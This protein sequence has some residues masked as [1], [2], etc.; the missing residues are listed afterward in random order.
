MAVTELQ[1][2]KLGQIMDLLVREKSKVHYAQ[3]RPMR[4]H[5]ITSLHLLQQELASPTGITMDCSESITL[6]C[7]LAG[8]ND[9]NGFKYDGTG[10]TGTLL[11]H[12]PHYTNPQEARTGALVVFGP[13][14]GDH[15]CMVRNPGKDPLLFSHGSENGPIWI[16][17]SD[18]KKYQHAPTTFLRISGLSGKE[19][20]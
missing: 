14:S 17:L 11:H 18:E 5:R 9:P 6:L 20:L 13:H 7:K 10:Y 19:P 12:L 8:L 1:R 2:H 3:I 15:V 4:T 16:R